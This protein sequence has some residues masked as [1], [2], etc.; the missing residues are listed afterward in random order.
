M[1]GVKRRNE[2]IEHIVKEYQSTSPYP[3]SVPLHRE[4]CMLLIS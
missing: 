2:E 4:F 3:F 1:G